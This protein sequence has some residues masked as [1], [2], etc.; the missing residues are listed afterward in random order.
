MPR[1]AV[2][3]CTHNR[4]TLL[5]RAL[6]SLNAAARPP[7]WEV[8][9][10]VAA[11]ACTDGTH[12][13]L[14]RYRREAPACDGLA[15]EWFA[16]PRP[17]KSFALNSAIPR[18]AAEL[19]T[20][21]D[22]DHRV[23]PGYLAGVCRAADTYP[24]ATMFCGR[25]L[26]DWDGSEPAWVH[27]E[28]PYKIRPLP[29][30][31]ADAGPVP[32]PVTVD[33]PTPGGGNLFVRRGVF[34]RVG[35][36]SADL[37]PHGHDL[38][39]GEDRDFVLRAFA[40]GE[41]MQY[42]PDVVQFHYVDPERL[43][44]G[45]VLRKAYQRSRSVARGDATLEAVPRYLWRM[46]GEYAA[47]ASLTLSP[48]KRRFYLVRAASTLGDIRGRRDVAGDIRSPR[49]GRRWRTSAFLLWLA[50]T[51]VAGAGLALADGSAD[52]LT[53]AAAALT[54]SACFAT[55]LAAKSVADYSQTGPRLRAEIRQYYRLY[56]LLAFS[57]LVA[58]A[59][60]ALFVMA[61]AGV[62]TYA[63]ASIA[64][65]VPR[66]P[67]GAAVA[68]TAGI[69]VLSGLQFCQHLLFVPALLAA[70]SHYRL[71]RL[72]P[73]WR[74][75]SPRRL[76]AS[77]SV[78]AFGVVVALVAASWKLAAAGNWSLLAALWCA[79]AFYAGVVAW[80][81][82]APDPRP[83]G[84]RAQT[85]GPPNILMIG[86]DTLRADRIGGEYPR[87]LAPHISRLA[88]RGAL[89]RNC[90][91]PCARTAPSLISLLTGVWPNRHGVRDNY[92][93]PPETKLEMEALPAILRRHGYFTAALSDWCGADLGK[94]TFGFD[95][96]DVPEDQWNL[97]LFIRQGP[98][99]L[100]LFLSL[101]TH[102]DL[103]R[104][105]LP[106][107]HYLGGVPLTDELGRET[108]RLVSYLGQ[109]D[110]PFFLNAFL[111]TT[112]GP[113]GSEY[114]YYTLF[115]APEYKG[116]SKFV[117]ARVA[118]PFDI[119]RRQ[120]EPREEFDLDQIINLY[121]ACVRRFDDEVARILSHLDACGLSR[122]TIVVLYSDHGME[123]F[124]HGTWGQG[125]SAIGDAST[126]VPML[127][128][129]PRREASRVVTDVVR[130][131]DLV[132]TLLEL[133]GVPPKAGVDGV[134]LAG[135]LAPSASAL[136]LDAFN[137]TG[138]WLTQLPGM[139]AD[140]LRYPPLPD[141]LEVPDKASGTLAIKPGYRDL[142]VAAKDRM[143]RRGRWKLVY[144]PLENGHLLKLFDMTT[145]PGC[146][147]DVMASN[148]EIA[149]R[150]WP[151]L[152]DWIRAD[153]A[154]ARLLAGDRSGVAPHESF[155]TAANAEGS[156]VRAGRG[157]AALR[158]RGIEA[159]ALYLRHSPIDHG[160]WRLL[161]AALPLLRA[162]GA[163]MGRRQVRC[164]HGFRFLADLGDWL[165]QYVYLTGGY[166]PPTA[167]VIHALVEPGDTVLDIGAN[168]GFFTL[169]AAARVGPRGRVLAFEPLPGVRRD[170]EANVGLNRFGNVTIHGA[171]VSDRKATLTLFEGP[172]GHKGL[173]SLRPIDMAVQSLAVPAIALDDLAGEIGPVK[174]AKIDVEGAELLALVGASKLI[175]RDR[176]HL[177][178][179]FTDEY[180][181]SFGHSAALLAEWLF[182]H[183]YAVYRIE[184][185]RL[186]RVERPTLPANFQFNALCVH[187]D[188]PLPR[189]L[190]GKVAA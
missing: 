61:A 161:N 143:L 72:Y 27:D 88:A 33:D 39:G 122:N 139:P 31:R 99:D 16:E 52:A 123:F 34:D 171:A 117:M 17:G 95:Y 59:L 7:G 163:S 96:V 30:P 26:P 108:R 177:V 46:L 74:A 188:R 158:R 152:E 92:V 51:A 142:V 83:L 167:A 13:L 124:E 148:G 84:A 115:S 38:G 138:I 140:H 101:F 28:G 44:F 184:E 58:Y 185:T 133:T 11:N 66:T 118:D 85:D 57:R 70:S 156:G 174:L 87:A 160:R 134:S 67:V 166:E 172:Q 12:A 110:R 107:L 189:V 132:P 47:G 55:L 173:S 151:P 175:A 180:L 22:D 36:F 65:G 165:G 48:A 131:V 4:A 97:K 113:F 37:G 147:T 41:T 80:M 120:A 91:V 109:L 144:Q 116:E 128:V 102:G 29:I 155:A 141:L 56:T 103:G 60:V 53:G 42:A 181:R 82:R 164:R 2:L 182:D 106:E 77:W 137:E 73:L 157:S 43:R 150:L 127:V 93:P 76:W 78:V 15:L 121:D 69:L 35:R 176:P 71:S 62:I 3:I 9:I 135:Y 68:A 190:A 32:K 18:I 187:R 149:S 45:Y 90:Y 6:A 79:A 1:L 21:V 114:P 75:L 179:E 159:A 112:H 136:E 10:L 126:R 86:S 146:A 145:D 119:I 40:G 111:S 162:E 105:L 19:V 54:I 49:V 100:R 94:Y 169:L 130:S 170:L 153:A 125:N 183:G 154:C 23:D 8:E 98:K 168:A 64:L 81:R 5:E 104:A 14:E 129:D 20:F 63:A 50:V 25:I 186:T 89:F 178:I 24:E